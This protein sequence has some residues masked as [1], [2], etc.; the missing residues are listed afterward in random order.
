MVAVLRRNTGAELQ[1]SR[2]ISVLC[3]LQSSGGRACYLARV[4]LINFLK[5]VSHD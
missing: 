3:R 1:L 4:L 5:T 2:S